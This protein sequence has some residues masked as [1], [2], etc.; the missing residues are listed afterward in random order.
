MILEVVE[1]VPDW[2]VCAIEY[3]DETGLEL[4][5][6]RALH[7]WLNELERDGLRP[8]GP[9]EGSEN[10]FCSSPAFGDA[11][12]TVDYYVERF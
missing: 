8:V 10:E 5:D 4:C 12:G 3:G 1:N 7:A 9:V 2:A 11:C 6:V